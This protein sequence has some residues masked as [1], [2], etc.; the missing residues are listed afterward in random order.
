MTDIDRDRRKLLVAGGAAVGVGLAGCIGP[1]ADSQGV[2]GTVER[3]EREMNDI[4]DDW[5]ADAPN[6][7]S[8]DDAVDLT[9]EEEVEVLNGEVEGFEDAPYVFEPADIVIDPGTTVVWEWAGADGHSVTDR[10]EEFDSGTFDGDGETWDYT[11]EEE[12][13]YEYYCTPHRSLGQKGRITVGDAVDIDSEVDAWLTSEGDGAPNWDGEIVDMTGEDEIEVINGDHEDYDSYVFEPAAVTVDVD[14]TVVWEWSGPDGHSVTD[15]DGEFDSE[16]LDGDG[17]TWDYTFE[18]P[19]LYRYYC[20]PH[21]SLA[22]LG[23]VIVE[24]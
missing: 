24:E 23:A 17:E 4:E 22:Q 16:T 20:T 6:W 14:T 12:G 15:E 10:D 11:F 8:P 9:G 18:E 2:P 1:F 19:G 7:S 5:L 13:I 3:R 21:R